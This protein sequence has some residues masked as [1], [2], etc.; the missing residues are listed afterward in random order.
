MAGDIQVGRGLLRPSS[1]STY[2]D[3]PRRFAARHLRDLVAE[4]GYDLRPAG[5]RHV[6]AT[7]GTA[8]H[9][10]VAATLRAKQATGDL[11]NATEIEDQAEAALVADWET[12]VDLDDT[13]PNLPVAKMQARRMI[14]SYRLHLA[15]VVD[16]QLVEER[17]VA[18]VGDGWQVSGQGDVLA[19]G[20]PDERVRDVKTGT[21]RRPNAP[22]YG[23][24]VLVYEAHGYTVPEIVEDY[25]AR[26]RR[27]AVQ[28]PPVSIEI[29]RRQAV[30][31]AWEVIS[32][33][34]AGVAEYDRRVADP[35]GM[36]PSGAFLAN[37]MSSLCG[38]RWCPAW[39][40]K[41]CRAH[42]ST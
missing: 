22:Q 39:G 42:A 34:K 10:G 28:P 9:A 1:L 40:T 36:E 2:A 11:G 19:N 27:D 3:C 23:G 4:A 12:G 30:L 15:P 21:R 24:Y 32:A 5:A 29:D 14:R 25:L 31:A 18:D 6:G 35:H 41:F 26:V 16:P 17:L 13:T 8:V 38:E 20:N 33:I 7:V 37:P